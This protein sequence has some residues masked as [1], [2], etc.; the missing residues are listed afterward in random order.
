M[1]MENTNLNIMTDLTWKEQA[2]TN[3]NL[4]MNAKFTGVLKSINLNA[5]QD[6]A[7]SESKFYPATID[8]YKDGADTKDPNA[9]VLAGIQATVY[10][11]NAFD[12]E[13]NQRMQIGETYA[14]EITQP[15]DPV[16][17]QSKAGSKPWISLSHLTAIGNRLDTLVFGTPA[18]QVQ[19]AQADL[20][21]V[22]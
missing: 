1:I 20:S 15:I 14:G 5:K 8:I 22:S 12:K 21:Q 11:N 18:P 16:T 3:G 17:K 2:T 4:G 7:G 10:H 13:G 6:I 9:K 19:Q